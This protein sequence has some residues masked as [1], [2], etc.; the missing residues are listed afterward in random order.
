MKVTVISRKNAAAL[1]EYV[2]DDMPHRGIVPTATVNGDEVADDVIP[3]AIPYGVPWS[4][5]LTP[6]VTADDIQRELRRRGIWTANDAQNKPN[7][8][9]AAASA[10]YG[11]D[12][13]AILRAANTIAREE[14]KHA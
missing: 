2:I 11:L 5:I 6:R 12:V 9:I 13:A 8:V 7:E 14:I 3:L 10:A 4:E 1:I